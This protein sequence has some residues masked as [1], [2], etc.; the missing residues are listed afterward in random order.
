MSGQYRLP[1]IDF[2]KQ[3]YID[4]SIGRA[5]CFRGPRRTTPLTCSLPMSP[6]DR[7]DR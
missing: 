7:P 6:H 5:R 2:D 1:G 3:V 4:Y